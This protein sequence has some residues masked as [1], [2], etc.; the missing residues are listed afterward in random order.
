MLHTSA[1]QSRKHVYVYG[2][3]HQ[4]RSASGLNMP[5]FNRKLIYIFTENDWF[6]VIYCLCIYDKQYIILTTLNPLFTTSANQKNNKPK[7]PYSHHP[8][9]CQH[10]SH[11]EFSTICDHVP[12]SIRKLQANMWVEVLF[13]VLRA[14]NSFLNVILTNN[15][16][17]ILK[18]K[19][20]KYL[21]M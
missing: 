3:T 9:F 15:I 17:L 16:P 2:D 1:S 6:M 5:Q 7:T 4:S 20:V 13:R 19:D 8:W 12:Q 10:R 18:T 14:V 21:N 11:N